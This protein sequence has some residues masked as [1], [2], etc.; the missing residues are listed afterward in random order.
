MVG[1]TLKM[2]EMDF[3]RSGSS[4]Q[5]KAI[6]RS[7]VGTSHLAAKPPTPCQDSSG[8]KQCKDYLIGAV[9][10]GAGSR[11]LSQYGSKLAVQSTLQYFGEIL[12]SSRSNPLSSQD[13]VEKIFRELIGVVRGAIQTEAENWSRENNKKVSA[14]EFACT[15]LV[16]VTFP[17][18]IAAMQLGDGFIVVRDCKSKDY[19]LLFPPSKGEYENVT[20]FVTS[21]S[22]DIQQ[23]LQIIYR[24]KPISF[25]CAS[26]DG[27][28]K[29][30][31]NLVNNK[32]FPRFFIPLEKYIQETE[33]PE[34]DSYI[35]DFL[36][37]DQ[38]N[39]RTDDDKTILLCA[40]IKADPAPEINPT[41]PDSRPPAPLPA[42]TTPPPSVGYPHTPPSG[43]R[44]PRPTNQNQQT[45]TIPSSDKSDPEISNIVVHTPTKNIKKS[46]SRFLIGLLLFSNFLYV[47][48]ATV[49]AVYIIE[50]IAPSQVNS[51]P[52]WIIIFLLFVWSILTGLYACEDPNLK[53]SNIGKNT[54]KKARISGL[55]SKFKPNGEIV[56]ICIPI[57]AVF[58]AFMTPSFVNNVFPNTPKHNTE[59]K[60]LPISKLVTSNPLKTD[61][62][63]KSKPEKKLDT[64][65]LY[66]QK[67]LSLSGK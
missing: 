14:G 28:E 7:V 17:N 20:T 31:L 49:A 5:W 57:F 54:N 55:I 25:V 38:I 48:F 27:L 22:T 15:L 45:E 18:G 2:W 11:S 10:D 37:L 42:T 34:Q 12:E 67:L 35:T 21:S 9:S 39:R 66:V 58:L 51:L 26:T 53:D 40:D 16:F 29:L 60:P 30:A 61:S 52:I 33:N 46:N 1:D 47:Y 24:S 23:D 13:A 62:C 64:I 36:N 63:D 19:D 32:A 4:S 44:A 43:Q 6:A 50:K 65:P 59:V 41:T 8:Y 56:A 3:Q